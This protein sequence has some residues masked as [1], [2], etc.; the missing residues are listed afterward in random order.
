MGQPELYPLLNAAAANSGTMHRR[1]GSSRSGQ[2]TG[3]SR[4]SPSRGT[5]HA[6]NLT[7]DSP[8]APKGGPARK[9][10]QRRRSRSS[11]LR[12]CKRFAAKHT[13]TLPLVILL[14]F[15]SLYAINPTESNI[16]QR[17]IF[18]SYELPGD[19]GSPQQYGKGP[20]DI[21]FVAFY[22]IVLAFTREF[23]SQEMLRP[24]ALHYG[25]K[26]RGK[27]AR[28]M[29]QV[30]TVLYCLLLGPAGLYVQSRTPVWYFDTRGMYEGFPHKTHEACFKFY[31]L[32]QAAYWL[33]QA[34]VM[35]LGLEKR[36]KDFKE[37]V[38][39][40][41][42]TVA[43]IALSYRFHFTYMGI[44][45][46]VTHDISDMFLAV[47]ERRTALPLI[48]YSVKTQDEHLRYSLLKTPTNLWLVML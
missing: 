31:Y 40:H 9:S 14:V 20:W 24:L 47:S 38:G 6:N 39:H 43:L 27:Q 17:F 36:R 15:L 46:Y 12:H 16:I 33:H 25:L 10:T 29:E 23:I 19:D 18:L 21:A 42:V 44:A 30:Y 34:L 41:I 28:F 3:V 48:S 26:S 13:W 1:Q 5:D 35:I 11:F 7:F 8:P 45:V 2:Q 4:G 22:T 37:L 32:F